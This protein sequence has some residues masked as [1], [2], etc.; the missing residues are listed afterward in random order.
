MWQENEEIVASQNCKIKRYILKNER[1]VCTVH[2]VPRGLHANKENAKLYM[3]KRVK[4][5]FCCLL[6][7]FAAYLLSDWSDLILHIHDDSCWSEMLV[8]H[9]NM[10]SVG[11]RCVSQ[12]SFYTRSKFILWRRNGV[13]VWEREVSWHPFSQWLVS[14]S[15]HSILASN[16]STMCAH[17]THFELSFWTTVW[18][19]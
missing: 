18:L 14:I 3:R 16:I 13:G 2:S 10:S 5:L 8:C 19:Y 9:F 1:C 4:V 6:K 17:R 11:V 7:N 15:L 12:G